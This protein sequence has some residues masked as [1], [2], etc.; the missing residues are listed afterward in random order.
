MFYLTFTVFTSFTPLTFVPSSVLI[1][2]RTPCQTPHTK[3]LRYVT[4]YSVFNTLVK[5][6]RYRPTLKGADSNSSIIDAAGPWTECVWCVRHTGWMILSSGAVDRPG[7][8]SG[9]AVS[10]RHLSTHETRSHDDRTQTQSDPD[11]TFRWCSEAMASNLNPGSDIIYQKCHKVKEIDRRLI[12]LISYA[13]NLLRIVTVHKACFDLIG[14]GGRVWWAI[15]AA[16]QWELSA[17]LHAS[18]CGKQ[19][20]R[21]RMKRRTKE[22]RRGYCKCWLKGRVK[23]LWPFL[24]SVFSI[25]TPRAASLCFIQNKSDINEGVHHSDSRHHHHHHHYQHRCWKPWTPTRSLHSWR[26]TELTF[27]AEV[28][29]GGNG[30]RVMPALPPA[31]ARWF[32]RG[33]ITV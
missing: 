9:R 28:R 31:P 30:V 17:A 19:D 16:G 18:R 22:D 24:C 20:L 8:Y 13:L 21:P 29:G 26:R 7:V 2:K 1:E 12:E 10:L 11:D 32:L 33:D 5:H 14:S 6:S 4:I 27:G 23:V 25:R 15:Q 3:R